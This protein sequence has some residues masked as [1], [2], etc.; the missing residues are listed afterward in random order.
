MPDCLGETHWQFTP[1]LGTCKHDQDYMDRWATWP[2]GTLHFR[3]L[4]KQRKPNTDLRNVVAQENQAN[5]IREK[6]NYGK[7]Y[8]LFTGFV[9]CL[10]IHITNV[11]TGYSL[12]K[13]NC[14]NKPTDVHIFP[15]FKVILIID[16]HV[17]LHNLKITYLLVWVLWHP[18]QDI[19]L[20]SSFAE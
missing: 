3:L 17:S 4:H 1:V 9:V 11:I 8:L 6:K 2:T 12:K 20:H 18:N 13:N 7:L 5:H 15:S 10:N 19:E 14:K 16:L